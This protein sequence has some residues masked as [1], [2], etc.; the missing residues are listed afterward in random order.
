MGAQQRQCSDRGGKCAGTALGIKPF[1]LLAKLKAN[2][3]GNVN[4]TFF[5]PQVRVS[6]AFV[7]ILNLANCVP[8]LVEQVILVND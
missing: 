8:G 6:K 1:Q 3:S 2:G 7:Q 5:M 4:K